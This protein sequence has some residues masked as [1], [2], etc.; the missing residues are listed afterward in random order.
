MAKV[1]VAGHQNVVGS[2]I[3]RALKAK[4]G[5]S[6]ITASRAKLDLTNQRDVKEF[7]RQNRISEVYL[8]AAKVGGIVANQNF[9]PTSFTK[10]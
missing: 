6:L 9:L 5:K 10:T 8:A 2:A 3:C 4:T 7:F 1:F